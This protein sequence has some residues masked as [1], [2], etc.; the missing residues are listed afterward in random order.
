MTTA[1]LIIGAIVFAAVIVGIDARERRLQHR[2]SRELHRRLSWY[3]HGPQRLPEQDDPPHGAPQIII[4]PS[5]AGDATRASG[6]PGAE[7]FDHVVRHEYSETRACREYR[8]ALDFVRA[9]PDETLRKEQQDA[10]LR[11]G[12]DV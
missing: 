12:G 9:I 8:D 7:R 2:Q 3:I 1:L 6:I 10:D 11:G 5:I 4:V